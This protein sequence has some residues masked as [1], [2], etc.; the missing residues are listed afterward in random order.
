MFFLLPNSYN[1][2]LQALEQLE[3]EDQLQRNALTGK[4][5]ELV[6]LLQQNRS[7][8]EGHSPPPQTPKK[9]IEYQIAGFEWLAVHTVVQKNEVVQKDESFAA[10]PFF[11]HFEYQQQQMWYLFHSIQIPPSLFNLML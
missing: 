4:L 5:R 10:N 11:N 9:C 8:T 7:S 2:T 6:A 1:A 3:M